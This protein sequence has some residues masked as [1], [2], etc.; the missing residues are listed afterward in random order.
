MGVRMTADAIIDEI[1]KTRASNNKVWMRLVRIASRFAPEAAA[2]ILSI[3]ADNDAKIN[4][5][6]RQLADELKTHEA[7]GVL[8]D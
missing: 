6:T 1:E 5:L 3:I 2:E 4:R 7:N 8:R